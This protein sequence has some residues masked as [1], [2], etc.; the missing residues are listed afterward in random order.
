MDVINN[1]VKPGF[2]YYL[3]IVTLIK[4]RRMKMRDFK[5]GIKSYFKHVLKYNCVVSIAIII[6]LILDKKYQN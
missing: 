6:N 3:R 2:K 4:Y 5:I 1:K